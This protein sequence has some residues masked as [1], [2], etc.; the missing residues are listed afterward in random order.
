MIQPSTYR[1][2]CRLFVLFCF[3][4]FTCPFIHEQMSSPGRHAARALLRP[5]TRL[6]TFPS[7]NFKESD[8]DMGRSLIRMPTKPSHFSLTKSHLAYSSVLTSL[9]AKENYIDNGLGQSRRS[10]FPYWQGLLICWVSCVTMSVAPCW[11]LEEAN[12]CSKLIVQAMWQFPGSQLWASQLSC[13]LIDL[14]ITLATN[15]WVLGNRPS[16]F[17]R[18]MFTYQYIRSVYPRLICL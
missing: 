6:V 17:E 12:G 18:N 11:R 13:S 9:N 15:I 5:V 2:F 3:V 16:S 8:D 1:H 14:D 10:F 7:R 4:F